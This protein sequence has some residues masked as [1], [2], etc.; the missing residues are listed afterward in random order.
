MALAKSSDRP[1]SVAVWNNAVRKCTLPPVAPLAPAFTT[2]PT[3]I[4]PAMRADTSD[5]LGVVTP[6]GVAM[7]E[8]ALT[9]AVHEVFDGGDRDDGLDVHNRSAP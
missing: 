6:D 2:M 7:D 1:S 9:R 5:R 8:R 3:A 4:D